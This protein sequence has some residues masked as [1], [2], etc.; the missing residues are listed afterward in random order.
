MLS[1][2]VFIA[3][4]NF[5]K[6]KGPVLLNVLG[7]STGV[8]AVLLILFYINFESSFDT[9]HENADVLHRVEVDTYREGNLDSRSALTPP[10]VGKSLQVNFP[11]VE[12]CTRIASNPGKAIIQLPDNNKSLRAEK[13]YLTDAS[14]FNLMTFSI[15]RGR[16]NGLLD[17][18]L[19]I[20]ISQSLAEQLWGGRWDK[21]QLPASVDVFSQGITGTFQIKA[22]Y[23]DFPAN[24][25]FKPELVASLLFLRELVGEAASDDNWDFKFFYT[26][27]KVRRDADMDRLQAEFNQYI[28]ETRKDALA[29]SGTKLKFLFQPMKDIH[30]KSNIQF[31]LESNGDQRMIY[32]L[33]IIGIV[34]VAIAWINFVNLT[35]ARG[36]TRAREVGIRKVFGA[37]KRQ[38]ILQF[39][40]EALVI[41]L[42]SICVALVMVKFL[43]EEFSALSGVPVLFIGISGLVGE[44]RFNIVALVVLSVGVMVSAIYPALMLSHY[45][46]IRA[47]KKSLP[48]PGG[49]SLRQSLV[50]LQLTFSFIA[51]A[52]TMIVYRQIT[53]MRSA[54]L[55]IMLEKTV[56]IE[57]PE[58]RQSTGTTAAGI[59]KTEALNMS[60]VKGVATSSVVPGQ[61]VSFRSYNLQSEKTTSKINCGMIGIDEDFI[62]NFGLEVIAGTPFTAR[63]N[64]HVIINEEAV[65]QLGFG[66]PGDVLRYGQSR[67][68]VRGWQ[69]FPAA[70]G[71]DAGGA[72]C[73]FRQGGLDREE[74]RSEDR[75]DQYQCAACVQGQD[76][77]RTLRWRIRRTRA[78]H[79]L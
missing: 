24:A 72:G 29:S 38:L 3:L 57:A 78:P 18:P 65:A 23:T 40:T 46:P 17:N 4:R 58:D 14:I 67:A 73:Q 68:G 70:G 6:H 79:R 49:L 75:R 36:I 12:K 16:T 7:I 11:M 10:A 76:P 74:R 32:G 35:T 9:F 44:L 47:L 13:A 69:N 52:A 30:L 15:V 5:S 53:F 77:H 1:T 62:G 22:I 21:V 71:H 8:T 33:G 66:D 64:D 61:E 39:T 28:A 2:Y 43:K 20:A 59:F 63:R 41:N 27:I 19:D 56:V 51:I 37:L 55:G 54:D 50:V 26:Y 42:I 34:I 60:F 31:E 25:H 45:N 48:R